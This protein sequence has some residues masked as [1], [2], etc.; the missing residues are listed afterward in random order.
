M[1]F[2]KTIFKAIIGLIAT[3]SFCSYGADLHGVKKITT[4]ASIDGKL[5]EAH[6]QDAT[7]LTLPYNINPGIN[8]PADVKTKVYLYE[9]G[10]SL[11]IAFKADD[12]EPEN[13]RAYFRDRDTIFQDD[14]VGI[15]IDTFNDNRRAYEFFVNPFGVQGDLVKDDTQGGNEDSN[16]DAIW[17]SAGEITETG[18]VVEM[19]IPFRAL[20]FPAVEG[21]M[22]W[23]FQL[24]RIRPR[25]KRTVLSNSAM[26]RNLDCD[27]C[28]YDKL[29]GLIATNSEQ[30]IQITPTLT[31]L[32]NQFRDKQSNDWNSIENKTDAGLDLR[33]G[34]N[35]NV[36]LNAT[37]NPDF[38]QVEADAAQLDINNTYS[39]FVNEKRP[40]FLDG[41]DYF[42]TQR[43]NLLHTRNIASPEYGLKLTGKNDKHTYGLL[44][45]NDESTTVL[46]PNRQ[47]SD[48]AEW[49]EGSD[50]LVGRY[51][52]DIGKR[53][54][55]GA[56]VTNRESTGYKNTV[57]SLDGRTNFSKSDTI[58]YQYAYSDTKNNLEL[59]N[60][61]DL[62][63]SQTDDAYSIRYNHNTQNYGYSANYMNYGDDFRADLGFES[64]TGVKKA[65][66]GGYYDW[67]QGSNK[68]W[69]RLG[70][71]VIGTKPMI[72]M[73]PC[74]K[75]SRRFM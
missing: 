75:K 12:P 60:Q 51:R 41:R 22:D 30:N 11:F 35:D 73:E 20:R 2:M 25:D 58:S 66:V 27:I 28:Q 19:E 16:W 3:M 23:G 18:Y 4:K 68:K 42:T 67:L 9:N 14:F 21:K 47:G 37:I 15:V 52:M 45:A 38:S 17:H 32:G 1:E 54:N 8:S 50:I 29:T 59:Q 39:L 70:Y 57:T 13:I 64:Q 7:E 33:W 48:I 40:F 26:D 72:F 56:I 74:L 36:F 65:V 46:I 55:I 49:N 24:L 71:L 43:M 10:K 69:S 44:A 5:T 53:S 31:Y 61:F 62:D 34:I 6:W 63:A